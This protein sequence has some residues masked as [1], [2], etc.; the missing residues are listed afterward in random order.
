LVVTGAGKKKKEIAGA[1]IWREGKKKDRSHCSS[2]LPR[3]VLS[4]GKKG[5]LQRHL[6]K[7]GG[8]RL[9]LSVCPSRRG[10]LVFLIRRG[11]KRTI[12]LMEGKGRDG[13]F[14]LGLSLVY[15]R[16]RR[17]RFRI[18]TWEEKKRKG[19]ATRRRADVWGGGGG[20]LLWPQRTEKGGDGLF[21]KEKRAEYH[22][23]RAVYNRSSRGRRERE[24]PYRSY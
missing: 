10:S 2:E 1:D 21:R 19:R 12:F 18:S 6:L 5:G 17:R 22:Y 4:A 7:K 9:N 11:R 13:V 24:V 15:S 23:C 14:F 20:L 3:S 16:E 8:G